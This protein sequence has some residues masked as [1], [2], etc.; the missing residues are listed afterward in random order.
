VGS[1]Y[2]QL[3]NLEYFHSLRTMRTSVTKSAVSSILEHT[4]ADGKRYKI[5]YYNLDAV[6][7][8]GYCANSFNASHFR[9]WANRALKDY[10]TMNLIRD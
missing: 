4:A 9:I 8:V 1:F 3:R 7:S 10:L 6:I 2:F 5:Q